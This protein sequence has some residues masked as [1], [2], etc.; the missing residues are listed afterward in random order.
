MRQH[1]PINIIIYSSKTNEGKLEL[2]QRVAEV[3][4]NAVQRRIK[5][6]PCPNS[7][8]LALLDAVIAD[9]KARA[10]DPAPAKAAP[11]THNRDNL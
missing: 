10:K 7:Q 11:L 8:K 2:A 4:A 3:H 1:G 6:L 9:A 5:E